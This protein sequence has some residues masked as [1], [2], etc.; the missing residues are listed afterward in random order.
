MQVTATI[1]CVA[2]NFEVVRK[3]EVAA[4]VYMGNVCAVCR[5]CIDSLPNPKP[6]PYLYLWGGLWIVLLHLDIPPYLRLGRGGVACCLGC[7]CQAV[8]C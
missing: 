7:C 4:V 5:R 3:A 1:I 6:R 2:H 8:C